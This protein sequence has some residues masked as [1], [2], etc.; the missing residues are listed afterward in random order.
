MEKNISILHLED[1]IADSILIKSLIS[2][3]LDSFDYYF[4]DKE[5]DFI[6]ALK[7]KKIDI[8][9][10]DYQLPDYSGAD[11]LIFSKNQYPHIP[12][13]FVT[14]KMGENT[15]IESLK[16]G[17]TDYVLKSNMGRLIPAIKRAFQE[18]VL[19]KERKEAEENLHKSEALYRAIINASPDDITITDIEGRILI[20]SPVAAT[21]FGYERMEEM[22]GHII[23]DFIAPQDRER[24]LS[25]IDMGF[26]GIKQGAS[27]YLGIRNDGSIINIE[28]NGE[29]IRNANGIPINMIFIVRDITKRKQTA[30]EMH[31]LYLNLEQ[32]V[33]ERTLLLKET[34]EKLLKEI[35]ER[36]KT[37]VELKRISTRLTLAARAGGIGVWDYNNV[38]DIL[39]WDDQMFVLYGI[40]KEDFSGAYDA[41]KAGLHP[42]DKVRGDA[43]IQAAIRGEKDFDTEFRVVWPDGTIRNIRAMAIVQRD[44]SGNPVHLIGTNWD[45]TAQKEAETLI[46][47]TR[48]NYETFFNTIDDFLF[49]LDEQGNIIHVND[50]VKTRL[51]Y[52]ADE[53]MGKSVLM[54]HPA[55]RRE[56]AGRIVG[57]MLAGTTEFCPVPLSAKSGKYIP[58]ETRVKAGFWDGKPVIF[59][60]TKDVSK[61]K[62]SEE[63]FS[64]AFQS[65]SA[66]MAISDLDDKFIDVNDTFLKTTGYSRQEVIGN[67][68][69][70]LNLFEVAELRNSI[71]EILEQNIPVRE[72]ELG[73]RTKSG[74]IKT[75]LFSADLIYIGK[76]KCLLTMLVDI[77]ERKRMEENFKKARNDA[78]KANLAKSEFL[79]RMS[80]ELRTPMNSILGFAQLLDMGELNSFQRKSVNHILNS[81]NHLLQLINEVLDISRIEAG[82]ISISL[83]PVQL[84]GVIME[85]ID[86]VY[87]NA[88]KRHQTIELVNSPA[89]KLFVKA[90]KK[91]LKQVLLNLLSNSIKYNRENGSVVIRTELLQKDKQETSLVRISVSDTGIGI[92][93]EDISKLFLPFERIGAEKT[94]T[95]GT[96]LGLTVIKKLIGIMGGNV[97]M[98]SVP[99]EGSTFWVELPLAGN[100][101]HQNVSTGDVPKMETTVIEKTGTILYIEDNISSVELVEYIIVSHRPAIRLITSKFGKLA[102]SSAIEYLPDLIFIDLDLPDIHGSKVLTNLQADAKT[103]SIPVVIISADAMPQQI[104]KFMDAGARD[105]LTKPINVPMF[106]QVVDEWIGGKK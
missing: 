72:V 65:N 54:V 55:E 95:E 86:V 63:K 8:V 52:S 48:L 61:I 12:F 96:G 1:Q 5:A 23:T 32:K 31:D 70:G 68:S 22:I 59:E 50:T 41:W 71:T 47:Q 99:G 34:N 102:V 73:V 82:R 9:L 10:S 29:F 56:E 76:D 106:L 37:E 24:A 21:M 42:D 67:T 64:R 7:E 17:A 103:R 66:L 3:G 57:E 85:M 6:E 69:G 89:N 80:H 19:F 18:S 38:D 62:L 4:V 11:A 58:V 105:Y 20:V 45:I 33:E 39:V 75:G 97:G 77:T 101:K 74:E 87:P 92:S 53:L 25:D 90:D 46:E 91:H 104:E 15:A 100:P 16:N 78:E 26:H 51:G 88:E 84:D 83:E 94:E 43:E 60:V 28:V 93:S 14:G 30:K 35:T 13:I 81:G 98:E 27:E 2:K 49:V 44:K 36:N 79:S 40:K